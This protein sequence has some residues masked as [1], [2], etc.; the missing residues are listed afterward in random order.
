MTGAWS[1]SP[2]GRVVR[3]AEL[4]ALGK[5]LAEHRGEA[6]RVCILAQHRDWI[7]KEYSSPVRPGPSGR[8]PSSLSS[9]LS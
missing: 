7:F 5:S 2:F 3:T 1:R 4:G 8:S 6:R 9:R